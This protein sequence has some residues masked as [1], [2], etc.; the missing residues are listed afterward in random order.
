MRRDGQETEVIQD[1]RPPA[2]VSAIPVNP[3]RSMWLLAFWDR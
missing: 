1:H 3:A 2:V